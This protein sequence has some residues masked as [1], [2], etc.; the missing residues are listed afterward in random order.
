MIVPLS[1]LVA[2][3]ALQLAGFRSGFSCSPKPLEAEGHE[4]MKLDPAG[5]MVSSGD[6]GVCT[7]IKLQNPPVSE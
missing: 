4:M 2:G 6:P 7:A 3:M 5:V 1:L